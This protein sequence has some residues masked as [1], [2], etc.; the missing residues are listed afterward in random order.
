MA[1]LLS[2]NSFSFPST[3]QACLSYPGEEVTALYVR[4][5]SRNDGS[6]Q[7]CVA[8]VNQATGRGNLYIYKVADVRTDNPNPTPVDSYKNCADRITTIFYKPRV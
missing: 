2:D 4:D 5:S 1:L 8:T 3:S 6:D 7:L